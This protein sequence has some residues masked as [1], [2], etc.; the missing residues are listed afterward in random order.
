MERQFL[1]FRVVG[2]RNNILALSHL[3]YCL[4]FFLNISLNL[5]ASGLNFGEETK[6][7]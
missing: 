1:T 3:Q 5:T 4:L 6:T 7:P 2:P